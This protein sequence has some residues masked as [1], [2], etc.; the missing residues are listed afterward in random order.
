MS[1]ALEFPRRPL[2]ANILSPPYAIFAI[3]GVPVSN[4]STVF[5]RNIPLSLILHFAPKMEI[6]VLPPQPPPLPYQRAIPLLNMC[7][8][9]DIQAAI[10]PFALSFIIARMLQLAGSPLPRDAFLTYQSLTDSA[11][12]LSAWRALDL[13]IAGA[14]GLETHILTML[15]LGPAVSFTET[16]ALWAAYP[17]NPTSSPVILEMAHNFIRNYISNEYPAREADAVKDWFLLEP[18][19][20]VFFR[21]LEGWYR[22]GLNREIE[23][24]MGKKGEE[25]ALNPRVASIVDKITESVDQLPPPGTG[26]LQPRRKSTKDDIKE[27]LQEKHARAERDAAEKARRREARRLR[28]LRSSSISSVETVVHDAQPPMGKQAYEENMEVLKRMSEEVGGS[29]EGL[30]IMDKS[31][32]ESRPVD[33]GLLSSAL[34]KLGVR[35]AVECEK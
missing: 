18:E 32:R 13:P 35:E 24:R 4:N 26:R 25:K 5:P 1:Y 21:D 27:T 22:K 2:P 17:S 23:R 16:K 30:R 3:R 29:L 20:R 8:G 12:I 11:N 10:T 34:E 33:G 19:R 31:F 28:R 14:K 9:I 7:I 15:M 6:W